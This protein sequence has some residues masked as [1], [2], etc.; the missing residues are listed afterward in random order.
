MDLHGIG[1]SGAARLLV[2]VG[3]I[4]RFPKPHFASWN[5]TA[6]IDASSGDQVRHPA[7][8]SR[9]PADQPGVAHHGHRPVTQPHPGACLLRP[10]EGLW[11]NVDGSDAVAQ[12]LALR[13]CLPAHARRR[14]HPHD[15]PARY[16][17][18]TTGS[19]AADSH[20][21]VGT[22]DKSLPGPAITQPTTA[23]CTAP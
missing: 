21:D 15:R 4:T 23:H 12:T 10:E 1:P 22:S 5:G 3:D 7:V 13:H 19:S 11:Q 17:G 20:P 18:A 6:P 2:E 16:R 8:T 14:P 9:K